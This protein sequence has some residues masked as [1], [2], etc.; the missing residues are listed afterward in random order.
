MRLFID[1][2]FAGTIIFRTIEQCNSIFERNF[3]WKFQVVAG[4]GAGG[5]G[6]SDK[7][8]LKWKFPEG[9]KSKAKLSSVEGEGLDIF[10][11]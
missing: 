2:V 5:G 10:G 8:P 7:H 3:W 4:G 11:N 6:G 9:D 1:A